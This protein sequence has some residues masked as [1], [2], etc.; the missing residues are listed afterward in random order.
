MANG[1]IDGVERL[2]GNHKLRVLFLLTTDGATLLAAYLRNTEF[3]VVE[4][5]VVDPPNPTA[6]RTE[7]DVIEQQ[8]FRVLACYGSAREVDLPG[9]PQR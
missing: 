5:P 7:N 1:D 9:R 3:D 8:D 2:R 6:R 4:A